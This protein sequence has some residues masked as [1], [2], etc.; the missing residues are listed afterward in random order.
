MMRVQ[1]TLCKNILRERSL[2]FQA[3]NK[4]ITQGKKL[5]IPTQAVLVVT[6]PIHQVVPIS[7]CPRTSGKSHLSL[8][9]EA[10]RRKTSILYNP[11][12]LMS[13]GMKVILALHQQQV[14]QGAGSRMRAPAWELL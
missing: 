3:N 14:P 4:T 7:S 10:A 13:K 9:E 5:L 1:S 6:N 11:M 8:E 12:L 2:A